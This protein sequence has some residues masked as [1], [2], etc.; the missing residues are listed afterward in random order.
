MTITKILCI[1]TFRSSEK[2]REVQRNPEKSRKIQKG[3]ITINPFALLK[4]GILDENPLF[5][6]MVALCP[7]IAVTTQAINGLGLGL[8]TTAVM[9]GSNLV[10]SCIRKIVPNTARI[11][12]FIVIIASFVTAV[13]FLL[14][15]FLPDLNNA[16]GIFIPLITSNCVV[17]ARAESYAFKSNP[18]SSL[19]DGVGMGLGF[20][21]A[22]VILGSIRE[23]LG[24]G[25]IFGFTVLPEFFPRTIIMILAPGGFFVMA[26]IIA[27]LNYVRIRNKSA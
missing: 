18:F 16:L 22:L 27:A 13:G 17:L 12:C 26:T 24:M 21:G 6:Q 3:E 20:T 19:V 10:I 11:P 25:E 5:I 8:A 23:F 7:A 14:E 2:F 9:A 4:R 1:I 15:G